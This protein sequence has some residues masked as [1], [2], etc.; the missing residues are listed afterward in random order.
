MMDKIDPRKELFYLI[1]F[2]GDKVVQVACEL[3]EVYHPNFTCMLCNMHGGNICFSDIGNLE[4]AKNL[5][6]VSKLVH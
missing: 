4:F 6:R 2:D 3:L 5:I 1:N